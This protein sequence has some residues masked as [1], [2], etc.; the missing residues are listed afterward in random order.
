MTTAFGGGHKENLT[1]PWDA[2][3]VGSGC[4][5]SVRRSWRAPTLD[6]TFANYLAANPAGPGSTKDLNVPPM[7]NVNCVETCT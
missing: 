3:D 6:E 4:A 1:T 5:D 2:D 7:R